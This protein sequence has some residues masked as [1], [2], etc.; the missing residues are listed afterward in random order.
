[1]FTDKT[2]TDTN[3]VTC[4]GIKFDNDEARR[5]YFTDILREKL[6]DPEFRKIEGFPI[7]ENEDILA[8][9]DPPYYTACPNPWLK[10]FIKEWEVQKPEKPEDYQY[11]REPFAADVSE[12]KNDPIYNAHSYHTKV[13]HKAIMR[14]ILHYTE[15]G[16]IVF[17]GFCGTGMT[18]VAA[19]MC[20]DKTA[21]ESLGVTKKSPEQQYK[22]QDDGIILERQLD[23]QGKTAW[24]PFS[25]LGTRKAVLNDLSPAATFIAYNYNTPV[26][27][28]AFER[29]A[30]QILAEVEKECG[31][32]YETMHT[33]GET[34]GKI[35]YT[36]WSDVF[37]CPE[38]ANEL[39]FWEVA[40]SENLS[41]IN[42][43]FPCPA[44]N[45]LLNKS[46]VE[47]A[48]THFYDKDL[49]D[50]IKQSKRVPVLI[51]YT[52]P[53]SKKNLL[54]KIEQSDL[55]LI[56]K[57]ESTTCLYDYPIDKIPIGDKTGE[58]IRIGITNAHHFY[59]NRNLHIISALWSAFKKIPLGRLSITSVLIK[60]ASLLHN[61]GLKKG[62]VNLAGALPNA[63]YI[64]SNIAERNLF[65][66]GSGKLD[67]F[68]RANLERN[69]VRQ[70]VNTSSLS[71]NFFKTMIPNS[72]D[73]I[74]IDPPFGSNLHYS[75]LSFLWE[76]WLGIITDKKP[77]AI[78]NRNQ[79]KGINKYRKL[80]TQCFKQ[81]YNLLRP[82]R[83]M[84]VE[85]SNTKAI[86]WNNIQTALNDAGFVVSNVS[87]L[88]KG[89]GSFNSQTNPTSV[90][91]DLIISA[92]KPNGGFEERFELEA[93][94]EEGVW[95]F[96]RTHL[97]YLPVIKKQGLDIAIVPERDPRI[98]FD[99]VVA[100]YVRK[101]FNVP[102]SSQEFQLGL[103]RRFS[104]RDGM[105][106]LPEQVAE[107]DRKK[108]IGGG[109]PI[110]QEMFVS[111]EASAIEWL[112]NILRDKPQSFQN[113]NPQFMQ[114]IGG[115]S[116]NEKPLEL[117][118]LLDQN[119]LC[120][121]GQSTVP[122]QIH[123]YLSTN[124]KDMRN[125]TKNDKA[126]MTKAKDRWY[127]PDP[128]KAGDLE[129]LREKSLMKEFEQY[130]QAT[131]KLKLF[132][133]EAVRAG[134]K[135][136]WHKKEYNTI[137]SVAKKIPNRILEEDPKL[138]M[139]YD[140]AITRTGDR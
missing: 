131:K 129:K 15:P 60:T 103:S 23:D 57:I 111:D 105:Y 118:I 9:S 4:L 119:F 77:E 38:C 50:T 20:G 62:K 53:G 12:G 24:K 8:L 93:Q 55:D 40:V 76:A 33:D 63:L 90:K 43:E 36:I 31:W 39:V 104:E 71:D 41:G 44:C 65:K 26:D 87:A 133:L 25:K 99:Q 59:T 10:D 85:F 1:M 16:D 108:M 92:Y 102:I 18:G 78:E 95:D 13:P 19:Q 125:R 81:A 89:Q 121:D 123:S 72:L 82:G 2:G 73:Y 74:F 69:K 115:W 61:I 107:Y 114:E 64:P 109:R 80:M 11:H 96:I 130:R 84:T 122:E 79:K 70:I 54:K 138:L 35:N 101:G 52:I 140:Q 91:Q 124:W 135:K 97:K 22:V 67:D 6:K 68:K 116:K 46:S 37:I 83:W 34:K 94:T 14:Y 30:K 106:F 88:N 48:W 134:F 56:E 98:L 42:S 17:D 28:Q 117:S 3:P 58:P 21:V 110:Q 139:W 132:R 7:G 27:V 75:E 112:R 126:L 5:I 128:N 127:V 86:I 49:N 136:A 29:E 66:L 47:R 137:I 51:N 120:Y 100:F 45:S 113:L 32:M